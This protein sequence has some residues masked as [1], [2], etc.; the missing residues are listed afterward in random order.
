MSRRLRARILLGLVTVVVLATQRPVGGQISGGQNTADTFVRK[1]SGADGDVADDEFAIC[2]G[3][4]TIT[5]IDCANSSASADAYLK[6]TNATTAN[7]TPGSTALAHTPVL[8]PY[9]PGS[10]RK[11]LFIAM[12]VAATGYFST[13][14]ADTDATD[15]PNGEVICTVEKR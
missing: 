13:G 11:V 8:I 4:C 3:P 12:S 15:V 6:V 1:V 14:F 10:H 9:G 5:A 2:T 7:T